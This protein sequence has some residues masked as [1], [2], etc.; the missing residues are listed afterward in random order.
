MEIIIWFIVFVAMMV[1]A[2]MCVDRLIDKKVRDNND[3]VI[4]YINGKLTMIDK[5]DK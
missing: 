4:E 5:R 3:C 1:M 2:Y